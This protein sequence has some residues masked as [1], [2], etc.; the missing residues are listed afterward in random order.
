MWGKE[1]IPKT[2]SREHIGKAQRIELFWSRLLLHAK[3]NFLPS[4]PNSQIDKEKF[5]IYSIVIFT[6]VLQ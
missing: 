4:E 6:F 2:C 3:E 5:N 1:D